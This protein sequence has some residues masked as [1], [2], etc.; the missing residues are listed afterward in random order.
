MIKLLLKQPNIELS[1][2]AFDCIGWDMVNLKD[3]GAI[4][5]IAPTSQCWIDSGDTNNN[6]IP[7]IVEAASGFLALEFL[8]VYAKEGIDNL[9]TMYVNAIQ[10]YIAAFPVRSNKIDCK[11]IQEYGIISDPSLKIGGYSL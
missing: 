7:D 6:E 5:A 9:G 11:T 4:A 1:D 2:V 10:N 8:R 3:G